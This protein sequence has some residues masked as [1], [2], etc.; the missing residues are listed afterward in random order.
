MHFRQS[1]LRRRPESANLRRHCGSLAGRFGKL[2]TPYFRE[3]MH[4]ST[5][6]LPQLSAEQ[7][8]RFRHAAIKGYRPDVT[9]LLF[10]DR[11]ASYIWDIL[12]P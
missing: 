6:N 11:G 1:Y 7:R 10:S 3:V 12:L 4:V 2:F 5:N 9:L 8:A